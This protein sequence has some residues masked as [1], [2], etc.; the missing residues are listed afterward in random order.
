MSHDSC[1]PACDSAVN[2]SPE[3]ADG[4]WHMASMFNHSCLPSAT[5][6]WIGDLMIV[7]ANRDIEVDEEITIAYVAITETYEDRQHRLAKFGFLCSCQLCHADGQ[8][9]Q[10][11]KLQRQLIPQVYPELVDRSRLLAVGLE[12]RCDY[13]GLE[14]N[15][16]S[17]M[18]SY[19]TGDYE[20]IPFIGMVNI[21]F[22]LAHVYLGPVPSWRKASSYLRSRAR[23]CFCATIQLGL[24]ITLLEDPSS[25]HCELL[26]SRNSQSHPVGILALVGLAELAYSSTTKLEHKRTPA[27]LGC[28]RSLY[29]LHYGEDTTFRDHHKGYRCASVMSETTPTTAPPDWN[30]ERLEA[31]AK[32]NAIPTFL[33]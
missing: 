2:V 25:V 14:Q 9:Q 18:Q 33:V 11:L 24:G 16:R 27:L 20:D 19:R 28:A 13:A 31:A 30:S 32:Q 5:Y 12:M 26:F 22:R 3:P 7:R 15:V 1:D 8:L 23:S 6:S 21:L 17:C 29:K 10:R 4:L